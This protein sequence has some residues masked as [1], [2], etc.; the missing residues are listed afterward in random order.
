M[1]QLSTPRAVRGEKVKEDIFKGAIKLMRKHGYKYVT[2]RNICS[3]CDIS[4]GTFYHYFTGK[5]DLFS[6]YLAEGFNNYLKSKDEEALKGKSLIEKIVA[7]D[8]WYI[9]YCSEPGL[10]F[11]CSYYTPQNKSLHTRGSKPGKSYSALNIRIL[12]AIEEGIE[13][14]EIAK[15]HSAKDICDDHCVILKGCIFDW[16]ISNGSYD[17][18]AYVEKMVNILFASYKN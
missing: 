18:I 4:T 12:N 7:L 6:Y 8:T 15:E 11:L 2:V 16:C 3:A 10:D 17:L 1:S 9:E 13:A 14:G 5:D